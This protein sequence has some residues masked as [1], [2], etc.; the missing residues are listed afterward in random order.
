MSDLIPVLFVSAGLLLFGVATLLLLRGQRTRAAAANHAVVSFK[1]I[2][3]LN[4]PT[5]AFLYVLAILCFG[6]AAYVPLAKDGSPPQA[7]PSTP[8]VATQP[9]LP[10]SPTAPSAGPDGVASAGNSSAPGAVEESCSATRIKSAWTADRRDCLDLH[11]IPGPQRET[12]LGVDDRDEYQVAVVFVQLRLSGLGHRVA[13]DGKYGDQTREAVED[14]Q[15]KNGLTVDGL[16]G[17][18]TWQ[19]LLGP[20]ETGRR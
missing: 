17:P 16:V 12:W 18:Q 14:Y 6:A 4:M 7:L 5:E 1:D 20:G 8:I 15:R 11:V 2:V 9:A 10:P 3:Q 13:V 19:S